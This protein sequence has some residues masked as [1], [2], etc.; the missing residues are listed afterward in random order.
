[1]VPRFHLKLCEA[2]G[3]S[4]VQPIGCGQVFLLLELLLQPHQLQLGEDGAAAAGLLQAGRAALRLRLAADAEGGLA[5]RV[6]GASWELRGDEGQVR[7][8]RARRR[9]L[10]EVGLHVGRLP[11]DHG[12]ERIGTQRRRA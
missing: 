4:Q 8:H 3:L 9:R 12:E 2:Q 1:M 5:G 6:F 11:R 10:R 7:G